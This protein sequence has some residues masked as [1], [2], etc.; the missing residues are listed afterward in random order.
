MRARLRTFFV[1]MILVF[2]FAYIY[3]QGGSGGSD[4][5]T[6][7]NRS[8]PVET[9]ETIEQVKARLETEDIYYLE[10]ADNA[11]RIYTEN[12]PFIIR[13]EGTLPEELL[14]KLTD[15]GIDIQRRKNLRKLDPAPLSLPDSPASTFVGAF[16]GYLPLLIFLGIFLFFLKRASQK[17]MDLTYFRKNKSRDIPTERRATFAEVGG[18]AEVKLLLGDVVDYLKD[19]A[20]WERSGITPPR[21]ILLEGPPGCGKTLIARAVAGESGTR[22]F[23]TSATEFIELFVGVGAAR[24]RDLFEQAAKEAPA[25][26]FIDELDAVGRRRGSGLGLANDER[27][28]T[29]NQLL[30]CLD[31]VERTGR[32]VVIAA[33]NRSDILDRALLRAGRFDRRLLFKPLSEEDRARVLEIHARNR[34]VAPDVSFAEIARRTEGFSGADLETLINEAS[35]IALR[36]SGDDKAARVTITP[37]EIEQALKPLNER[38]RDLTAVDALLIDS[39]AHHARPSGKARAQIQLRHGAPVV[40]EL[41]WADGSFIRMREQATGKELLL[42]KAQILRIESLEGTEKVHEERLAERV[43]HESRTSP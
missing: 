40:G 37:H 22:F 25:V 31:G 17:G 29:L 21:G 4:D 38:N 41:L 23:S 39:A 2:G 32:V 35:L 8:S 27:E 3:H 1:W 14:K 19:P 9:V 6:A 12:A 33:T 5:G 26:I 7:V 42:A 16:A 13:A 28:Q 20:K 15:S 11:V 18:H 30:V 36:R 34:T 10:L 24:V 43:P